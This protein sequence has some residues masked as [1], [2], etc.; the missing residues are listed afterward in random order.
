[1]KTL[2][3]YHN[4]DSD[5]LLSETLVRSSLAE[6][7]REIASIGLDYDDPAPELPLF[8]ELYMVDISHDRLLEQE[9]IRRR[10][11]LID[12]HRTAIQKWEPLSRQF[13][14]FHVVEGKGAC[15][16]VWDLLRPREPIP[17]FVVWV[18]FRDVWAHKGTAFEKQAEWFE[19]GLR[20][21]WPPNFDDILMRRS[22]E[23]ERI[24]FEGKTIEG[25]AESQS[26]ELARRGAHLLDWEG[27]TFLCLNSQQ[28]GSM[29]LKGLADTL[30]GTEPVW[31][32]LLVWAL[33]R[34]AETVNLSMYH[35]EHSRLIDLSE[36]AKRNGGGGH[37]GAAGARIA[38]ADW[39]GILR[40]NA[41]PLQ[42]A[43]DRTPG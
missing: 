23:T 33:G 25:Y 22:R 4:A 6:T 2:I 39:A 18:G 14:G 43:K 11:I 30:R 21:K 19:L 10:T 12:H 32:A 41:R 5:G 1:M 3:V 35:D 37:P 28:R 7:D 36:I 31:D 42:I 26:L 13:K 16:L 29:T 20:A 9:W 15:L 24:C 27:L 8:D 34:N 38:F 40:E 17:D